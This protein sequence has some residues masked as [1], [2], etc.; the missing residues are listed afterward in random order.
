MK[1]PLFQVLFATT[2]FAAT[3]LTAH[4]SSHRE[5]LAI[6][7]EPC[8]DNTD[9]YAW[10]SPGSH[11]KLYLIMNFNPLH[12]PG[13][14]N[15]GLRACNGYRYEFHIGIGE[16]LR[17]RMV[18]RVE[19][20]NTLS[21]EAPPSATDPLGGGNELLWQLTGG[22]ET[23]TVSRVVPLRSGNPGNAIDGDG[24]D[25]DDFGKQVVVLAKDL[26]V[27]PNNHGPQT[28]RL[29]YGLGAFAGYDSGDPTSRE[30]GLYDQNFVDSFIHPLANGGRAIAGQ[31]DDPYQLD[32]KGIFDLVNLN[33]GDLGGIP[34]ARRPPGTD[35]FTG[36]NLF[37]I[38]LE[39]P[40]TDI[41]PQG[42]PHNGE[43]KADST[44]SL[45]RIWSSISRQQTQTVDASNVITGLKG[46]GPFVQVGRNALPLFN[47]GLVGTQR[48]TRYLRGSPLK[49]VTNFGA[50]ILFP[51]L[52]RDAEALGI[53]K[54]LGVP[55]GTVATLKG[56]RTDIIGAIN[57]GR[58]IPVADGFTGDVITLDTAIDSSFPN[59]RR[60]GGGTAPNRNQV[61]VNTVLISLIVAGNPAAGLAKGIEVNDKDYLNRFPFLAPAH[62]G[63]YQGHGGINVPTEPTPPPPTP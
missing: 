27:L 24:A 58:P 33:K 52:V 5:A 6:L 49:D 51:V 1:K 15:Q 10:V 39:I 25:G 37:S 59:G 63:L 41:F 53:Y 14:G 21:P 4:G 16:S 31:F 43:L 13:Q 26:P 42:I 7:N 50:D 28:D 54:A 60:L 57:L 32:E 61:N 22:T 46:S 38:A 29:V 30:V 56:P 55:A 11:D 35:V 12:E 3:G 44:D 17:D 19:F 9:T 45:L 23:M 8:A 34:G 20:K 40:I 48:Q 2:L 62:Q 47:A 18:Y 36:F